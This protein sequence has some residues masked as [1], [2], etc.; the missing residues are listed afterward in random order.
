M[1]LNERRA[2]A[3]WRLR[4]EMWKRNIVTY[5]PLNAAGIERLPSN[6]GANLHDPA[7]AYAIG[8]ELPFSGANC[9]PS[10]RSRLPLHDGV[11]C[12]PLANSE[13]AGRGLCSRAWRV[14]F[15]YYSVRTLPIA[16]GGLEEVPMKSEDWIKLP[17]EL[18]YLA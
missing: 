18:P 3:L 13:K 5:A 12:T 17:V 4:V 1:I 15:E 7:N 11:F 10:T 16:V 8:K 14:G 9:S 6:L 2:L